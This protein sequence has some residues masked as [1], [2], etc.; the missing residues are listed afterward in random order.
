MWA[1]LCQQLRRDGFH[2]VN[3]RRLLGLPEL[4]RQPCFLCE[5]ASPAAAWV[6]F[7]LVGQA[8]AREGC[9]VDALLELGLLEVIDGLI[10]SKVTLTPCE[11][12]FLLADPELQ[13]DSRTYALARLGPRRP[14]LHLNCGAGLL[15]LLWGGPCQDANPRALA[16]AELNARLNGRPFQP[17]IPCDT[18]T[19][20]LP[21]KRPPRGQAPH[22]PDLAAYL[23]DLPAG[24]TLV[25]AC[26][27]VGPVKLPGYQVEQL[28]YARSGLTDY[29]ASLVDRSRLLEAFGP[30]S[31][32]QAYRLEV[33]QILQACRGIAE[34]TD[35]V[36]LI[37][38]CGDSHRIRKIAYPLAEPEVRSAWPEEK[39]SFG[40]PYNEENLRQLLDLP[41]VLYTAEQ[42]PGLLFRLR[43]ESS[44]LARQAEYWLMQQPRRG[45][46]ARAMLLPCLGHLFFVD[47]MFAQRPD[48]IYWLG[49]DSLALA[50]CVPRRPRQRSL[51]LCTGSGVQAVLN[52]GHCRQNLAV[53][54]NPRA[55]ARARLNARVNGVKLAVL[56]GSLFDPVEPGRFDLIT[57]NPPFVP[58][59]DGDLQLFRPG[60]ESGEEIIAEIVQALPE[61]LDEGGLLAL[62]S[63]CPIMSNSQPLERMSSWLGAQRG[64]GLAQLR[65]ARLDRAGLIASHT[66]QAQDFERWWESYR[67]LGIQGA[68]LAVTLV[69][70]LPD[71]HPGFQ[72]SLDLRMPDFSIS[73]AVGEFWDALST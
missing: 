33:D 52:A 7:W 67:R 64:W 9:W 48:Q 16:F 1:E 28:D 50:R 15:P 13:P 62:V 39:P 54:I 34:V 65:F 32:E 47:P 42:I 37:K 51:D 4:V 26:S 49:P 17:Q 45:R 41:E 6:N 72:R 36:L 2:E 35:S 30:E 25:V 55:V 22:N 27:L 44:E 71:R 23:E 18:V 14:A 31:G 38:R 63:Q 58:T 21:M 19:L 57:A 66:S 5:E 56:Q 59:P 3:A 43:Q 46:R 70:R 10:R 20:R 24:A 68:H 12:V 8:Q 40:C 11:D 53:D 29:A 73:S 69:G 61:R 60:G